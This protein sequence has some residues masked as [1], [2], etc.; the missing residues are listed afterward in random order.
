MIDMFTSGGLA[1]KVRAKKGKL[2]SREDYKA[3]CSMASVNAIAS[4]LKQTPSYSHFLN[5]IIEAD[6]HRDQLER[7]IY[8]SLTDDYI[9]LYNFAGSG[10][11]RFL[12]I[13]LI[14]HEIQFLKSCLYGVLNNTDVNPSYIF[15]EEFSQEHY[16]F[17]VRLLMES[18]TIDE[19]KKNLLGTPYY[20]IFDKFSGN[21]FEIESKLDRYYFDIIEETIKGLS[22][23]TDKE[24]AFDLF[25]SEADLLNILWLY[26]AKVIYE[27][28]NDE[29]YD[30]II[31]FGNKLT[32][33]KLN[34]F[35]ASKDANS[36][37]DL[38]VK[39]RYGKLFTSF[40]KNTDIIIFKYMYAVNKTLTLKFPYAAPGIF[41][42]LYIKEIEIRNITTIIEGVRYGLNPEVI[43]SYL[44]GDEL[45][46]SA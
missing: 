5:G 18:T 16:S 41:A 10:N 44:I 3:M 43:Y 4:Y 12:E 21:V 35:I 6:I 30:F 14:K 28:P 24:A 39:S 25:G 22:N 9:D 45:S 20:K 15:N 2:L 40:E 37:T 27:I 29:I 38:V 7:L 13:F 19:L 34:E 23:K 33:K 8:F 36:F 32:K 17:N 11:R 46:V 42:Y 26:R 1:T 31:P